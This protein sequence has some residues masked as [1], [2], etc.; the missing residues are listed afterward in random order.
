MFLVRR[1]TRRAKI[2]CEP[3]LIYGPDL[4]LEFD[5][6]AIEAFRQCLKSIEFGTQPFWRVMF[7]FLPVFS[8][9][10]SCGSTVMYNPEQ[11][12]PENSSFLERSF[13][14]RFRCL[15]D[16]SSGFLVRTIFGVIVTHLVK[17]GVMWLNYFSLNWKNKTN[18]TRI[19]HR[20]RLCCVPVFF[21]PPP[22]AIPHREHLKSGAPCLPDD[23]IV[24]TSR[25]VLS[26]LGS[27]GAD[28]DIGIDTA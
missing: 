27:I 19:F 13:V 10:K 12:P 28:T 21:R 7:D 20:V 24:S 6:C 16:N 9:L 14:C 26:F 4:N 3:K 8:V 22:R 18:F 1:T 23:F 17:L 11:L 15:L 25:D 5:T 2:Y